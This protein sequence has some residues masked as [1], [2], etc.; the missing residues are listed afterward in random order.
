MV[1]VCLG[2]PLDVVR[3]LFG[4]K[5]PLSDV[6]CPKF[7]LRPERAD[8]AGRPTKFRPSMPP[9][10]LVFPRDSDLHDYREDHRPAPRGFPHELAE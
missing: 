7:D 3:A 8:D 4:L 9:L 2:G 5:T 10:G 6:K 1:R